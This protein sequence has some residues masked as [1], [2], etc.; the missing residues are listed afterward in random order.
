[1]NILIT[2][3]INIIVDLNLEYIEKHIKFAEI[4]L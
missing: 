2:F 3:F 4:K 1:M